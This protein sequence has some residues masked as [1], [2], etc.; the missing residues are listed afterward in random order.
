[1]VQAYP[2]SGATPVTCIVVAGPK[3]GLTVPR[4]PVAMRPWGGSTLTTC[5]LHS[6]HASTSV[7]RSWTREA[8]AATVRLLLIT[9]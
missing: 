2:P 3:N 5:G 7:S 4:Q 9:P 1:M 6:C 8:G